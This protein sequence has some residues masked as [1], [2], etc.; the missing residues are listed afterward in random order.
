MIVNSS[1]TQSIKILK[2]GV[3]AQL[4]EQT[5]VNR[6]VAGSSPASP[7]ILSYNSTVRMCDL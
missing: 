6:S 1:P 7:A 4:V 5:A 3:L 2:Y